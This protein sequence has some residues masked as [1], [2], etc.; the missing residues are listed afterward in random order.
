M[1]E[2]EIDLVPHDVK[3]LNSYYIFCM[4]F[5]PV[6]VVSNGLQAW[7]IL[8][9]PNNHTD[10]VLTEVAMPVLSG[11]ALLCKIMSHKSLKN[12]PVISKC[13]S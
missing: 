13:S 11:I 4:I 9:D 1:T 7:K 2:Q 6:N 12:I 8:E 10:I 3:L 5:L